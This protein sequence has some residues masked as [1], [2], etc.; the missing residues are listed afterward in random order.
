MRFSRL[1]LAIVAAGAGFLIAG[2]W[3]RAAGMIVP[4]LAF[5]VTVVLHVRLLNS[6]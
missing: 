5:A 4:L 2:G 6:A 3:P 1:R